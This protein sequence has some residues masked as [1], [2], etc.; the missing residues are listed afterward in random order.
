MT[1]PLHVWPV[2]QRLLAHAQS[3]SATGGTRRITGASK[4]YVALGHDTQRI[5]QQFADAK[6]TVQKEKP[7]EP[8]L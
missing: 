2:A 8:G 3:R 7:G 1:A 4:K 6:G 5:G